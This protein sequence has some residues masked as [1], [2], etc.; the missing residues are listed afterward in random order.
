MGT[1]P[2]VKCDFYKQNLATKNPPQFSGSQEGRGEGPAGFRA[3]THK[4]GRCF[5]AESG[6]ESLAHTPGSGIA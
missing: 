5:A 1:R 2:N 3:G 4:E 6:P